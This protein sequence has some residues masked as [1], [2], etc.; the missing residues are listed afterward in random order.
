[1]T[2]GDTWAGCNAFDTNHC[3]WQYKCATG[4]TRRRLDRPLHR[5]ADVFWSRAESRSTNS[6]PQRHSRHCHHQNWPSTAVHQSY[7]CR[8]VTSRHRLVQWSLELEITTPV[9]ETISRHAWRSFNTDAF[10][11]EPQ[12]SL[13]CHTSIS[14][15]PQ[16]PDEM[17]K[18][19]N[20]VI[21]K[22]LD[23]LAPIQEVTC[24]RWSQIS[25]L[26]MS[27]TNLSSVLV[28]SS[29]DILPHGDL[30]T[31][32]L[33]GQLSAHASSFHASSSGL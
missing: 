17:V 31:R 18:H 19:Y 28:D 25:G 10:K 1:M 5:H 11:S 6:R 7:R 29:G 2:K 16:H 24:R 3:L 13:L 32:Q 21:T 9:Y 30:V 27:V 14:M 12:N 33:G 4:S 22:L 8:P 26:T 23:R 15:T 20:D